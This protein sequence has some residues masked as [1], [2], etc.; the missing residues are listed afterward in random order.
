MGQEEQEAE[1][2]RLQQ[3]LDR[4]EAGEAQAGG[5]AGGVS[6]ADLT[7]EAIARLR[8]RIGDLTRRIDESRDA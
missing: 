3:V 7:P 2:Q 4:H 6:D 8:A 1:R 5:E